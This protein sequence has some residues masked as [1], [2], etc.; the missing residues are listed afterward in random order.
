M[1]YAIHT[2]NNEKKLLKK[3]LKGFNKVDYPEAFKN[4][5]NKLKDLNKAIELLTIKN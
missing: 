3:C 4:R 2:L 1:N 5:N